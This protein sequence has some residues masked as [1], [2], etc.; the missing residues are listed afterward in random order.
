MTKVYKLHFNFY[1]KYTEGDAE[2]N[3]KL[4]QHAF[5]A[6][7]LGIIAFHSDT[8]RVDKQSLLEFKKRFPLQSIDDSSLLQDKIIYRFPKLA[9]PRQKVD[10]LKEKYNLSVTRNKDKADYLVIS[11]KYIDSLVNRDYQGTV[12]SK[13][14]VHGLLVHMRDNNYCTED[15]FTAIKNMFSTFENDCRIIFCMDYSYNV[16]HRVHDAVKTLLKPYGYQGDKFADINRK[17]IF[18]VKK[19]DWVNVKDIFNSGKLVIDQELAAFTTEDSHVFTE[20][21]YH[22]CKKMLRAD[23]RDNVSLAVEMMANCNIEKSIPFLAMLFYFNMDYLKYSKNWNTVNVKALRERLSKFADGLYPN[24]GTIHGYQAF[25]KKLD[26]EGALTNFVFQST[27]K[28]MFKSVL[29]SGSGFNPESIFDMDISV[30]KLK[31]EWQEKL[32][33]QNKA[34]EISATSHVVLDDLP[35]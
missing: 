3:G 26:E 25:L 34:W 18:Y 14:E 31:P 4:T 6:E 15:G 17:A 28:D 20:A 9:L 27:M 16:K 5:E 30:L 19:D 1:Q 21:D 35:F 13:S 23:D 10:L 32:D 29:V 33:T 2:T 11:D 12:L 24:N 7:E 22:Q 8:W